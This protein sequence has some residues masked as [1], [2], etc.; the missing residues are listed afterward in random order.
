MKQE[1]NPD[2]LEQ[3]NRQ[4]KEQVADLLIHN[5]Y[6]EQYYTAMVYGSSV[7]YEVDA[8]TDTVTKVPEILLSFLNL[9]EHTSYTSLIEAICVTFV[10]EADTKAVTEKISCDA[11]IREFRSGV[12]QIS[13][14][15]QAKGFAADINWYRNRIYLIQH[16]VSGHICG[17]ATIRNIETQK[18]SELQLIDRAHHDPLTHLCN[19]TSMQ[20]LVEKALTESSLTHGVIII[21]VDNFKYINDNFGHQAGDIVLANFAAMLSKKFR[22][23]DIV[24]RI[25]GDEFLI[26]M[27][28]AGE[29]IV[30]RRAEEIR[31]ACVSLMPD[32][33][34]IKITTSIGIAMY[35]QHGTTLKKLYA[36]ADTA[37]YA[38]K[39][40]GKNRVTIFHEGL[41]K[42]EKTEPRPV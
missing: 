11:M 8:T 9:D 18:Q 35:P 15:Y 32:T 4:L 20:E 40:G 41:V 23:Y 22:Q 28:T 34:E 7:V 30:T 24:S 19:R 16:P 6:L 12:K 36:N 38:S 29:D 5:D 1:K 33:P 42:P 37:L 27:K 14:E 39:T 3:E 17:V 2:E 26:F 13:A 21:D 10:V 25:G 31:Q